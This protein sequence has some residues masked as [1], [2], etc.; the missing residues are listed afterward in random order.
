[1]P[2]MSLPLAILRLPNPSLLAGTGKDILDQWMGLP[3]TCGI[4]VHA[5]T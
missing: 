5:W 3:R 2:F 4:L 1:M